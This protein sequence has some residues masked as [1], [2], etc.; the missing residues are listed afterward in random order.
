[1]ASIKLIK[2]FYFITFTATRPDQPDLRKKKNYEYM[3]I[4]T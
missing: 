4:L 2:S 3:V 1:M